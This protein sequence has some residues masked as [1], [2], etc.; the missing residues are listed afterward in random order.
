MGFPPTCITPL[1][2]QGRKRRFRGTTLLPAPTEGG[3]RSI[4]INGGARTTYQAGFAFPRSPVPAFPI[5]SAV[6]SGVN[7]SR[8]PQEGSPACGLPSLR[9]K[10]RDTL[11]VVAR[12]LSSARWTPAEPVL[13]P[14]TV[15]RPGRPR[16]TRWTGTGAKTRQASLVAP[17]LTLQPRSRVART[18]YNTKPALRIA[19]F[20]IADLTAVLQFAIRNDVTLVL[21]ASP[22]RAAVL[23]PRQI[24][25]AHV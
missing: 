7:F 14:R 22:H 11:S 6:G 16:W 2:S 12:W 8:H 3:R 10:R 17:Y 19:D 15:D 9:G 23:P 25:R 4:P 5:F 18:K 24:G 21:C 13:P 20:G 1:S